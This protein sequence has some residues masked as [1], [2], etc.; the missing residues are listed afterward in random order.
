MSPGQRVDGGGG[1]G[2]G[3]VCAGD[4]GGGNGKE[5]WKNGREKGWKRKKMTKTWEKNEIDMKKF[6]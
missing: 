5:E 4:G 2:D 6:W 3:G 1:G